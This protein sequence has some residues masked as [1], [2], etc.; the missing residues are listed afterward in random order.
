MLAIIVRASSSVTR[1]TSEY[2]LYS[3]R[4]TLQ[5][6]MMIVVIDVLFVFV[7]FKILEIT[8]LFGSFILGETLFLALKN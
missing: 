3:T 4:H 5:L 6:F 7:F 8:E 2:L 1:L